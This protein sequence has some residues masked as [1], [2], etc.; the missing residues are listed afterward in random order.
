VTA[1]PADTVAGG[2]AVGFPLDGARA[3][4]ALMETGGAAVTVTDEQIMAAVRTVSRLE[5]IRAEPSSATAIAALP[6]LLAD[7][8]LTEGDRVVV[9][10]TGDGTPP[11]GATGTAAGAARIPSTLD[12][13]RS[14]LARTPG[15]PALLDGVPGDTRLAG[16]VDQ[17][18]PTR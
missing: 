15:G 10:N 17:E 1:A 11:V 5:G 6:G 7:G 18:Q 13:V 14:A 16:I 9:V 4:A 8:L 3:V 12:A 2:I